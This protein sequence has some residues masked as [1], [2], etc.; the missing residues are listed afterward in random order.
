MSKTINTAIILAGG[1]SSRMGFNKAKMVFKGRRLISCLIGKLKNCPMVQEIYISGHY[2]EFD[3]PQI[4]DAQGG[5]GPLDGIYSCLDFFSNHPQKRRFLFV[6]VDMPFLSI[7]DF[8]MLLS[9]AEKASV[10]Y[11]KGSPLPMALTP[12]KKVKDWLCEIITNKELPKS[13]NFFISE[14]SNQS[15]FP[16]KGHL[17]NFNRSSDL[18][19]TPA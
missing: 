13:V 9:L 16:Q 18:K 4:L 19:K 3:F 1:K 10:I 15:M 8:S 5:K 6:P 12:H 11:F 17:I 14:L 7:Q 2:P